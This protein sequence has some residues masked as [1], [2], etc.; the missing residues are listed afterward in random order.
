MKI[1]IED[2]EE[3]ITGIPDNSN[4]GT[5]VVYPNPAQSNIV[6]SSPETLE[7]LEVVIYDQTGKRLQGNHF[8][9]IARHHPVEINIS[10][11]DRGVYHLRFITGGGKAMTMKFVKL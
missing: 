5:F 8:T 6:I 2:A 9:N 10:Q 1:D 3:T 4:L 7:E 11:L